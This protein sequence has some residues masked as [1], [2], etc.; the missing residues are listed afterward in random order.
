MAGEIRN[1]DGAFNGLITVMNGAFEGRRPAKRDA[2]SEEPPNSDTFVSI[3]IMFFRSL[4]CLFGS[5]KR[6]DASFLPKGDVMAEH[7]VVDVNVQRTRPRRVAENGPELVLIVR[8]RHENMRTAK[9]AA[10]RSGKFHGP[11]AGRLLMSM[12]HGALNPS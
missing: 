12:R 7:G 11:R 10:D 6:V 4:A 1:Q 2:V 8:L 3:H 9:P 5:V